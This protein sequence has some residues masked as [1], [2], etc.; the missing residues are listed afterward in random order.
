MAISLAVGS[1]H[2][3]EIFFVVELT[4]V[5]LQLM[6]GIGVIHHNCPVEEQ[7]RMVRRVKVG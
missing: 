6:G 7:A 4:R 5:L 3:Q 1:I 2:C